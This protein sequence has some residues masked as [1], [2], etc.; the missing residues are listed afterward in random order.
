MSGE[1]FGHNWSKS[2][3]SKYNW[4]HV[5]TFWCL[6]IKLK[7][8]YSIDFS[9]MIGSFLELSTGY[10]QTQPVHLYL[11]LSSPNS[12]ILSS[13]AVCIVQCAS[14]FSCSVMNISTCTLHMF[15]EVSL[16]SIIWDFFDILRQLQL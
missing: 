8:V 5:V 13:P 15:F 9:K 12:L 2:S 11:A 10:F 3:V 14:F 1:I 6:F 7:H 4:F 16:Y